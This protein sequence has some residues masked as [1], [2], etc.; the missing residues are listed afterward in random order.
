MGGGGLSV[1]APVFLINIY[2][3]IRKTE[4]KQFRDKLFVYKIQQMR[5]N[6]AVYDALPQQ[7]VSLPSVFTL[8]CN[9][10]SAIPLVLN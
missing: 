10:K 6:I 2:V 9:K 8:V 4:P 5:G 1:Y 7:S 3:N